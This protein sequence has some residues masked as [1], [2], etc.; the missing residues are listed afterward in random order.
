MKK[1]K[2][3]TEIK[4]K[5]ETSKN[6]NK[7]QVIINQTDTDKL[8]LVVDQLEQI[9]EILKNLAKNKGEENGK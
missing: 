7:Q 6:K 4:N 9:K 1:S 5:T 2:I 3:E 8:N